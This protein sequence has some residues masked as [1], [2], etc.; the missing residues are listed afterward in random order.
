MHSI[1]WFTE[2]DLPID[3]H[4]KRQSI[5]MLTFTAWSNKV[6]KLFFPFDQKCFDV[7]ISIVQLLPHIE[8]SLRGKLKLDPKHF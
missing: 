3:V 5:F 7:N 1:W 2:L 6:P 4:R 8:Y